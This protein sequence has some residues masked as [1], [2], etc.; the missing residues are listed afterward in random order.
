MDGDNPNYFKV[1]DYS[2]VDEGDSVDEFDFH[3]D[4]GFEEDF[5]GRD[6]VKQ[7]FED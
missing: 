4:E 1:I 3:P 6:G 7:T 2:V 5:L